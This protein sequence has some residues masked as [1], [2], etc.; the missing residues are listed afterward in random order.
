MNRCYNFYALKIADMQERGPRALPEED[1]AA[2]NILG[3]I[4]AAA[5]IDIFPHMIYNLLNNYG[6]FHQYD[7]QERL[8]LWILLLSK[9]TAQIFVLHP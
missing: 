6:L 8:E 9:I 7:V 3:L 4:P 1:P 2:G 5:Q